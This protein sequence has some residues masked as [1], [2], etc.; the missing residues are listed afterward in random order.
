MP[1][2]YLIGESIYNNFISSYPHDYIEVMPKE[3]G[4]ST[5]RLNVNSDIYKRLFINGFYEPLTV[6][7]IKNHID[8]SKDAIDVGA[9]IGFYSVFLA[10]YLSDKSKVLCIEPTDE[11]FELLK[12]NLEVNG[13][14]NKALLFKGVCSNDTVD[15]KINYIPFKE[16]YS[17]VGDIVHPSVKGQLVKSLTVNSN[18][19]D[20]LVEMH[21]LKPGFIKIDVEGGEGQVID[22]AKLTLKEFRPVIISELC[23]SF[24]KVN[25]SSAREVVQQLESKGYQVLDMLSAKNA[26]G[27]REYGEIICLPK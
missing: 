21:N 18:T 26:P 23:D 5:Y 1:S 3:F 12:K 19:I 16:E 22:G 9:N 14:E 25:G 20:Q 11:A 17:S 13:V 15:K 8:T 4:E 10:K 7:K 27:A 24:L 2:R 6:E